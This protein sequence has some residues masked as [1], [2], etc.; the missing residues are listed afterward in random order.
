VDKSIS[1]GRAGRRNIMKKHIEL[2]AILH[3]VYHSFGFITALVVVT[4]IGGG[5]LI[6]GDEFVIAITLAVAL[7]MSSIIL[8]FSIPGIIGGIGLLKM[9]PWARI[10]TLIMGFLALLE[11]PFGTALGIYTIWALMNDK[12]IKLFKEIQTSNVTQ[13][14]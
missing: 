7:I 6:S 3:I 13:P 11:I 1:I 2:I 5:G 4:I 8:V 14:N 9:R 10:L 12:T